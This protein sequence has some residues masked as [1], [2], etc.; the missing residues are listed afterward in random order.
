MPAAKPGELTI[1]TQNLQRFFD[2]EAGGRADVLPSAAYQKKLG[3]LAAQVSD[4]LRNPHVLAVQEAENIAVLDA[5]AAAIKA[6]GGPAYKTFLLEGNDYGGIDVGFL[7]RS[8]I[9]VAGVEAL[10]KQ[11][12][13]DRAALFDR[14]PLRLQLK[15]ASGHELSVINVHLKSLRGSEDEARARKTAR[16]RQRQA[17]VLA[18]WLSAELAMQPRQA[19]VLLGDF[20]ATPEALGGVDVLGHIRASGLTD[21]DERLPLPERYSYVHDCRGEALD[22]VLVSPALLPAVQAVAVSRGN[23]GV[24]R[25]A[26]QHEALRSADHDGLVLY[27]RLE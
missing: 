26:V 16:K 20:N 11:R 17:E 18:E 21:V 3:K 22:H 13:L 19:L 10:L 5:L 8:D 25:R 9:E 7:L 24:Q 1:A 12:K 27:L 2:D 23:A 14:P 6:R 4:V 15:L